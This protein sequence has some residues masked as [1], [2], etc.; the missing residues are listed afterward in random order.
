M[1]NGN[2]TEGFV[3]EN[4]ISFKVFLNDTTSDCSIKRR[5]ASQNVM[6]LIMNSK[7]PDFICRQ[8]FNKSLGMFFCIIDEK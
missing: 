8:A 4:L 6:T 2:S 3:S 5:C 1:K 7:K